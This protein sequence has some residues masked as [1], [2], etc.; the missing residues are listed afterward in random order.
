MTPTGPGVRVF[1]ELRAAHLDEIDHYAPRTTLY[2]DEKYDLGARHIPE[3]CIRVTTLSAMRALWAS[4]ERVLELPEPLWLRFF[5]RWV[6]FAVVWKSRRLIG[7]RRSEVVFFAIENNTLPQLLFSDSGRIPL[8]QRLVIRFLQLTVRVLVDRCVFG[9]D[10]AAETYRPLVKSTRPSRITITDLLAPRDLHTS[11]EAL[12]AIFVG[13]LEERKGIP[14]LLDCWPAVESL[15][16]DATLQVIG[17]GPLHQIV[18]T[19]AAIRPA[20]RGYL[21]LLPR[22]QTLAHIASATALIAPSI[23]VGRWREQV[24]RPIQEA[25]ATGATVVT[26]TDTGL[27]SYL[28]ERGHRVIPVALL[29][30]RLTSEIVSALQNP[31]PPEQV[32]AALPRQDGRLSADQWLHS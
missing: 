24:G 12:S 17:A 16:P 7:I 10:G 30:E 4:A 1:P 2:F 21:G 9:T 27:A 20:S 29:E 25:L 6:L 3:H 28:Q 14:A 22:D 23:P 26:T 8:L 19:W 31:L 15:L 5:P 32:T 18:E 13:A 11:K